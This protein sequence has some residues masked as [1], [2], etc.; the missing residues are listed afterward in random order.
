MGLTLVEELVEIKPVVSEFPV[1]FDRLTW[2]LTDYAQSH[3]IAK[4][5]AR[6]S[7]YTLMPAAFKTRPGASEISPVALNTVLRFKWPKE[8]TVLEVRKIKPNTYRY[9]PAEL[10]VFRG[11]TNDDISVSLTMDGES[12]GHH[13]LALAQSRTQD[14][15]DVIIEEPA[16][17]DSSQLPILG[18]ELIKL[19]D[20]HPIFAASAKRLNLDPCLA[21]VQGFE[22]HEL[23][24][25]ALATAE[26][27]VFIGSTTLSGGVID[28]HFMRM[29]D[30]CLKRKLPVD[31][32]IGGAADNAQERRALKNLRDLQASNPR[33]GVHLMGDACENVLIFDQW[34]VV[35]SFNWLGYRGRRRQLVREHYGFLLGGMD[36]VDDVYRSHVSLTKMTERVD[37]QPR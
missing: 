32:M 19:D 7:C 3:L 36:H 12:S 16:I 6:D 4:G 9:L 11:E 13:D 37:P 8:L 22:H 34:W 2:S 1:T 28:E 18:L 35:S 26:T 29:L 33:L 23:L 25:R 24:M 15:L 10:L 21:E 5:R 14:L 30:Q 27:R 20:A 31:L 17:S